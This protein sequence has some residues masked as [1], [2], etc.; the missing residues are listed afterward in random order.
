MK[1]SIIL[2]GNIN[3]ESDFIYTFKDKILS[4]IHSDPK[5]RESKKALLITAAWRKN[6]YQE[7]HVKEALRN[8]GI[9]S[10]FKNGYDENIQNLAIYHEFNKFKKRV[11]DIYKLYHEKQENIIAIKEFY[12]R[13]NASLVNLLKKQVRLLKLK[14][15]GTTLAD[16]LDYDIKK[17]ASTLI[18]KNIEEHLFHYYCRDIQHTMNTIISMD[19]EIIEICRE[20]DD[21][22]FKKSQVA[23]DPIYKKIKKKLEER[24][25]SANSIFIFGGHVAVLFNRLNFFKLKGAFLRALASGTNFYTVSA[26]SDVLCDKIILYGWIDMDNMDPNADFEFFDN[27]F[28]LITKLTLFPHCHDRIKHDDPDSLT[29]LAYRWKSHMCVGLDQHSFLKLETYL[30]ERGKMYE[31]YVSIGKDE[32]VYV[33]DKS[34]KKIILNYGEELDMPGSKLYESRHHPWEDGRWP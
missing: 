6:E 30:D 24:I 8:I 26:G 31:R 18:D 9:K 21:Y 1:G 2:N 32:G 7:Q 23:E 34:G 10:V 15:P 28:G 4:S 13:K 25:L 12:R 11:P 20:I 14:F 27:G 5:V 29:Y 16:I 33:F 17:E 22:F 3:F 19:D